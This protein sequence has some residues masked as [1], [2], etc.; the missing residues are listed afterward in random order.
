MSTEPLPAEIHYFT[1]IVPYVEPKRAT[2]WHPDR[3]GERLSRG[4]FPSL[5][6]AET[7]AKGHLAGTPFGV[8]E[9][10]WS[11]ER[12][13]WSNVVIAVPVCPRCLD[14]TPG[15][16]AG[17]PEHLHPGPFTDELCSS[18]S[19]AVE[20]DLRAEGRTEAAD[21]EAKQRA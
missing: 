20:A 17:D 9:V 4:A 2:E 3:P 13:D 15:T 18:C 8:T 6:V 10:G 16:P 7:W 19:R 11:E 1:V 21:F 5:E 12:G 14:L